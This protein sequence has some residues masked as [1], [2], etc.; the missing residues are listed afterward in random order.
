[1]RNTVRLPGAPRCRIVRVRDASDREKT[2]VRADQDECAV[3]RIDRVGQVVDL[4]L[5]EEFTVVGEWLRSPSAGSS[6]IHCRSV[7][8]VM[9]PSGIGPSSMSPTFARM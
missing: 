8:V 1:M 6:P 5:R 3:A 4:G 9:A 7:S 2:A